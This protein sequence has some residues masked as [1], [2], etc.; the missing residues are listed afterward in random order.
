MRSE[1][2]KECSFSPRGKVLDSL[3]RARHTKITDRQTSTPSLS[4]LFRR[5]LFFLFTNSTTILGCII[6]HIHPPSHQVTSHKQFSLQVLEVRRFQNSSSPCSCK[7]HDF[8]PGNLRLLTVLIS[9]CGVLI[10]QTDS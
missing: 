6:N 1:G 2:E 4:P 5:L 3:N 10:V 7:R 8:E 9:S